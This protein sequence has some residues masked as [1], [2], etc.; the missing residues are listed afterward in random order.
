MALT[1][2]NR[3]LHQ[4]N[5]PAIDNSDF[6]F[7]QE[8]DVEVVDGS[9]GII[10]LNRPTVL[11]ALAPTLISELRTA[12]FVLDQHKDIAVII[13]KGNEK[14]FAAGAD[15]SQMA[16]QSLI[17]VRGANHFVDALNALC[18]DLTK[19]IISAVSGYAFGG[20]L[21]L[22]LMT[23]IV[24]AAENAKF[25]LPE[26]K[27][28]T[29][30]GAGGTQRLIR[31]VGKSKA[32]EMILTGRVMDAHEAERSGLV[33]KVVPNDKLLEEALIIAKTIASYSKPVGPNFFFIFFEKDR[34]IKFF[35]KWLSLRRLLMLLMKPR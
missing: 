5:P 6:S 15:I 24:I 33:S 4:I 26:I 25:A 7:F 27:L 19:P 11:N 32:M 13:V 16:V 3:I 9:I 1:R 14:A 2:A 35:V 10:T 17:E 8:I 34:K 22:A 21:E 23:D 18:D 28:G 31:A 12:F 30:P 20:G 29:I